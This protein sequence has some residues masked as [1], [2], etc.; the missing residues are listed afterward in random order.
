MGH[1]SQLKLTLGAGGCCH[2]GLAIAAALLL[3]GGCPSATDDTGGAS[4]IFNN[5][6][7]LTNDGAGYVG[8]AACGACHPD[9]ADEHR[10]HGHSHALTRVQGQ[11]PEYAPEGSRA[12]VPNPPAGMTWNDVSYVISGY[13]HGAFFVDQDGFVAT[14]G[15]TGVNTQWNLDSPPSGT[16]ATFVAYLPG[17]TSPLPY[18]Y[19][20]CFRCHTTGPQPQDPR[21][22]RSQD[23]RP[24]ILG[25]WVE[26][27]VQ[28]EV[29]HGP[30]S[31]HAPNPAARDIFVDSTSQTC[32]RCH[33]GGDNL[34]VIAATDGFLASNTQY[35]QL[36]ASGGH[37]GFNCT[38]CHNPHASITYDRD[39]GLRNDCT[40]CHGEA[41][42]AF[43]GGAV[44][45]LGDYVEAVNCESCHMPPAALST[46]SAPAAL[47][48]PD[49]RI[50]DVR[51]HLFRINTQDADASAMFTANGTAVRKDGGG[52]AAVTVDFVCLRC[53]KE[54][55]NTF[56]LTLAGARLIADGMH[57]RAADSE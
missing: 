54:A 11:A 2:G 31:N 20:T 21:D 56:P 17:Q 23:G 46:S 42:M 33:A 35:A 4:L 3:A 36:L 5:A 43:H 32:G 47:V 12:G 48:G 34:D 39:R 1:R 28:C 45:E 16:V 55:G 9:V 49:A 30:G 24:G 27:S 19:E 51:A 50:G 25:T 38:V 10:V 15:V 57:E 18:D 13:L 40:V 8:S 37:S 7:D 53:H 22:R 26:P 29:C 44:F 52:R 41:N 14:D 6:T